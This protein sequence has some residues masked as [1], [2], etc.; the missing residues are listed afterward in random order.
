MKFRAVALAGVLGSILSAQQVFTAAQAEAG[1]AIYERTC[2]QCHRSNLMGRRG[3]ADELPPLSSLSKTYQDFV[4]ED[5]LV[6][7][8]AGNV[9]LERWGQKTAGEL[10]WRFQE[11]VDDPVLAFKDM[12]GEATVNLTAYILQVN[13]ARAGSEALTRYT[14]ANVWT[15]TR[16]LALDFEVYRTQVEPI[17]AKK[18]EGHARCVSCHTAALSRFQL[19]TPGDGGW[20]L[21]QSRA[22]FQAVSRMVS[23]GDVLESPILKHPLAESAGGDQSHS[24]GQQFK[25][26]DDPDWKIIEGWIRSA[27]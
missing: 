14:S 3:A 26:R 11:T 12:G 17:F 18:R 1:R 20:T 15:I 25:T 10:V 23:F 24:G 21:E 2:G 8:L 7:P 9:F 19:Q 4:G 22:N 27:K 16:P 6:P 13:G 5:G